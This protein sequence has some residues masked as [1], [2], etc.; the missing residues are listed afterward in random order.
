[1]L[2]HNTLANYYKIN[3]SLVH[4]RKYSLTEIEKMIIFE[5]DVYVGL[6]VDYIESH[7]NEE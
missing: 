7:N 4:H 1:M 3:F 5:Q 6:L 2:A